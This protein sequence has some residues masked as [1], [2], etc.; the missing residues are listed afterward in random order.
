MNQLLYRPDAE[1]GKQPTQRQ[2]FPLMGTLTL[3]GLILSVIAVILAVVISG[4]MGPQGLQ[5]EPGM[6]GVNGTDGTT[7]AQ[8]PQGIQGIQGLQGPPGE[9]EVNTPPVINI[10]GHHEYY[11]GNDTEGYHYVFNITVTTTDI[12][13]DTV[14]TIIYHR[15]TP[16]AS[17]ETI[18]LFFNKNV[19]NTASYTYTLPAPANQPVYWMILAWDGRDI[20]TLHSN[21]LLLYP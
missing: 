9:S 17:W 2:P 16:Y 18:Q 6:A 8:G 14:Q 19:S 3:L 13:N 1:A 7:G 12:D 20:T 4:P 15:R 10:T 11:Y 21:Y 5:G